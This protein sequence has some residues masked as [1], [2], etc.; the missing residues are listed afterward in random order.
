MEYPLRTLN[1]YALDLI[2]ELSSA[3]VSGARVTFR[4]IVRKY[5]AFARQ[6]RG[7]S[8]AGRRDEHQRMHLPLQLG[9]KQA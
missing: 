2:N 3:M 8:D 4:C 1:G 5:A 9:L 6:N 7:V